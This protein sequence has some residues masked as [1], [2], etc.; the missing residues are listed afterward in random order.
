MMTSLDFDRK[1]KNIVKGIKKSEEISERNKELLLNFKRDLALG[2]ASLAWQQAA[3]SRMKIIAQTADFELDEATKENLKD[4]VEKIQKRDISE[5]TVV[6]YQKVLK[7]FYKWN[8]GGEHP[9]KVKWMNTTYK[10]KN[11]TLPEVVLTED[12]VKKLMSN[13]KTARDKALISLLWETGARIGELIDLTIRDLQDYEHGYQ[14]VMDGKTGNRRL[15]LISSVPHLRNWLN[16][17]PNP[18]NGKPL[19]SKIRGKNAGERVGYRYILKMLKE[20]KERAGVDKPVNPHHFRHSRATYLA[21]KFTEAQLCEW[22]GWVQ[23]SDVPAKYVHMSGR[24]IDASYERLHGIKDEKKPDKSEMAPV[25]CPR[26]QESNDPDAK[27]CQ[28]CG[29]VLDLEVVTEMEEDKEEATEKFFEL[30][31]DQPELMDDMQEFMEIIMFFRE[32]KEAAKDFR[33]MINEKRN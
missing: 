2:G 5:T 15:P 12:D 31:K 33:K 17:H 11:H 26:C 30:S 27:F 29:Q 25:E 4:L 16:N 10:N 3:L 7:R 14:I 24:D 21:N 13:T 6:D 32:N 18:S 23:G 9:D 22:F 20:T 1:V 8:N 19:W 28:R